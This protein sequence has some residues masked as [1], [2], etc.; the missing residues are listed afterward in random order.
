MS[1]MW[2][3]CWN[4]NKDDNVKE[5]INKVYS[6]TDVHTS[7]KPVIKYVAAV[8]IIIKIWKK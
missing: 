4:R 7:C 6:V 2:I 5:I 3:C 1:A 8:E